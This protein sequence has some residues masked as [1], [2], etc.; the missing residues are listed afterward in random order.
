MPALTNEE[1][2]TIITFDETPDDAAIFTYNKSW[3][4]HLENK[5][6]LKSTMNNGYGGRE[7][8]VPKNRIK[9]PRVPVKISAATRERLRK[10][11][12]TLHQKSP[13]LSQKGTAQPK[14][15]AKTSGEGKQTASPKIKSKN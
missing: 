6:G 2:E 10:Q 1:K 4:R 15:Q 5:L 13:V 11:G 3:Q 9:P 7:Y 14:T 8:R 12:K